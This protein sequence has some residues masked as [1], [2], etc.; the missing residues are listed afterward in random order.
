MRMVSN[1][2]LTTQSMEFKLRTCQF[3]VLRAFPLCQR[4]HIK[5][6]KN[7]TQK[8]QVLSCGLLG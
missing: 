5:N 4:P 3:C 2:N 7:N 6:K 8:K 1:I